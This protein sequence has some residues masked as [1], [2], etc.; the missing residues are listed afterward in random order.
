MLQLRLR[1]KTK[2]AIFSYQYLQCLALLDELTNHRKVVYHV[3]TDVQLWKKAALLS[4]HFQY[5]WETLKRKRIEGKVKFLN[6]SAPRKGFSGCHEHCV[7]DHAVAKSYWQSISQRRKVPCQ[8]GQTVSV[9]LCLTHHYLLQFGK[10]Q[11][12]KKQNI[13]FDVCLTS[14][15]VDSRHFAPERKE[16]NEDVHNHDAV[17]TSRILIIRLQEFIRNVESCCFFV[18]NEVTHVLI[19]LTANNSIQPVYLLSHQIAQF[20]K[21]L[22][23]LQVIFLK[24]KTAVTALDEH[25]FYFCSFLRE[26]IA[27]LLGLL[28]HTDVLD[29]QLH[30]FTFGTDF[31]FLFTPGELIFSENRLF[32]VIV[33]T[34][35]H[36]LAYSL[37]AN[38]FDRLNRRLKSHLS[39]HYALAFVLFRQRC[40]CFPY[41][42]WLL[43]N[44]DR[45]I[46][47]TKS[48]FAAVERTPVLRRAFIVEK[49]L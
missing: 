32:G 41:R 2:S 38:G 33:V 16:R 19:D 48:L 1:F 14:T 39:Q 46:I 23:T 37:L 45:L 8:R 13:L 47:V 5:D 6:I 36:H 28:L 44:G 15:A 49:L 29:S 40:H 31:L 11:P 4:A 12:L 27:L 24:D 35:S 43:I 17:V 7:I 21:E 26:K 3:L 18:E 20:F 9:E 30:P 34:N 42:L 25:H 22:T 10:T